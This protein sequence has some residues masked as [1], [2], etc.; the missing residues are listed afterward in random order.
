MSLLD[1]RKRNHGF[2]VSFLSSKI[3][4]PSNDP[5][6]KV[7]ESV[8]ENGRTM[9]DVAKYLNAQTDVNTK[10][11]LERNLGNVLPPKGHGFQ[12]DSFLDSMFTNILILRLSK[13]IW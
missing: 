1:I 8:D 4:C 2:E 6:N 3:V 7:Y 5:L 10:L 9:D 11:M 12:D 13:I